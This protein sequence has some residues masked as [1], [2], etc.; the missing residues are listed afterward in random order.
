MLEAVVI[1]AALIGHHN[2]RLP[3]AARMRLLVECRRSALLADP[4]QR[5]VLGMLDQRLPMLTDR[6]AA[7]R[8]VSRT[9]RDFVGTPWAPVV[10]NL[11]LAIAHADQPP[12]ARA[13]EA[14]KLLR[15]SLGLSL[16]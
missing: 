1:A 2:A 6:A 7:R 8:L 14:I 15:L 10:L 12:P 16:P 3:A 11:A 9:M 13:A 4:P 5:D